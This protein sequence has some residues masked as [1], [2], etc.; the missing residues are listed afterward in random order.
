MLLS[1]ANVVAAGVGY[2]I[3]GDTPTNEVAVIVSVRE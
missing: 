1:N 3:A 2:K